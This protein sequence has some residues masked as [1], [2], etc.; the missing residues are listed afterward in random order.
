MSVSLIKPREYLLVELE[1][2]S[3]MSFNPFGCVVLLVTD[4]FDLFS[5]SF[6]NPNRDLS[7]FECV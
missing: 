7:I 1:Q 3:S 4:E 5:T 2:N 6:R